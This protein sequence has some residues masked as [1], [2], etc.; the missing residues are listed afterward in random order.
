MKISHKIIHNIHEK[1]KQ[2]LTQTRS[3]LTELL[4]T[5]RHLFVPDNCMRQRVPHVNILVVATSHELLLGRM[6]CKPP[7]LVRVSLKND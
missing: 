2:I 4:K 1:Y 5:N 7:E 3:K 6:F